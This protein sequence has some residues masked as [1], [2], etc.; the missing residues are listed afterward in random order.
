MVFDICNHQLFKC[1]QDANNSLLA[2]K[3]NN[4]QED[5]IQIIP[6]IVEVADIFRKGFDHITSI[7]LNLNFIID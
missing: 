6:E 1:G 3:Y 4:V 7:L 2:N 5:S